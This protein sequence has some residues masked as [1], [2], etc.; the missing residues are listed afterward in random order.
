MLEPAWVAQKVGLMAGRHAF[1]LHCLHA[2]SSLSHTGQR[3]LPGTNRPSWSAE[4]TTLLLSSGEG[5]LAA[6]GTPAGTGHANSRGSVAS[7]PGEQLR[8]RAKNV[9]QS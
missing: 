1:F 2:L 6:A 9:E 5:P 4:G 7:L 3:Q 8:P